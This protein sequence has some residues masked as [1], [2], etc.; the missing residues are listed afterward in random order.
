MGRCLSSVSSYVDEMVIVD[1]GSSDRSV[2]IA[3][4]YGA[5]VIHYKWE[6][7]FAK[8]RN[9]SLAHAT[10]DWILWMDADE[11][12]APEDGPALREGISVSEDPLLLIQLIN[13]YGAAPPDSSRAYH[14]AHHRLIRN[15]R[16]FCFSQPIHE[17]LNTE[18]VLGTVAA[19]R[20]LPVRIF[21][22]GYMDEVKHSKKKTERNLEILLRQ[23]EDE[24]Y[25]P[26]IDYHLASEWMGLQKYEAALGSVNLAIA[27]FLAAGQLPPSIVYK[28]KYATLLEAGY[29][30]KICPAIDKAIRIYPDYVDL[31][32]YK[33]MAR[34]LLG[35]YDEAAQT[36]SECIA[37]GESCNHHL[38][39]RGTGSFFAYYY[40]GQCR[41]HMGLPNEASAD[42]IAALQLH[43]Q[44]EQAAQALNTLQVAEEERGCR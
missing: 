38:T 1:T 12:L 31:Y 7:D 22:Y 17:Q 37:I 25:S 40:R 34:F 3:A 6:N 11:E 9:V 29:A 32:F 13:Y 30:A 23:K 35:Q 28:L 20:T 24:S 18:A 39:M 15:G 14:I 16:G 19:I 36:F 26:W 2:E 5:N 10:G 33:G 21:H 41:E 44:F 8:A 4:S 27:R 43:P 42:Y